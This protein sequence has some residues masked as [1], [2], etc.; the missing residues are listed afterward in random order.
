MSM[1]RSSSDDT[2]EQKEMIEKRMRRLR[3]GEQLAQQQKQAVEREREG[4]Q[5]LQSEA[6]RKK[7]EKKERSRYPSLHPVTARDDQAFDFRHL[8]Q[9][10]PDWGDGQ[11]AAQRFDIATPRDRVL[12]AWQVGWVVIGHP[13]AE[14]TV[15]ELKAKYPVEFELWL[16]RKNEQEELQGFEKWKKNQQKEKD[17]TSKSI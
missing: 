14:M 4:L 12:R 11:G 7:G 9:T 13:E 8:Q 10:G 17:V 3:I 1:R 16:K 5:E 2:R 6:K 15:E